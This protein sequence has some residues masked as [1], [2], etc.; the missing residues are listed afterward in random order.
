MRSRLKAALAAL[1]ISLTVGAMTAAPAA[2][3]TGGEPDGNQHPNVGLI[4]FYSPDGRFRCCA[5]LVSPTVLAH[6]GPLHRPTRSGKTAGGLPF[7]RG[8]EGTDRLPGGQARHHRLH[9][10]RDRGR[11]LPVRHRVRPPGLLRL[12][13]PGQ[14]ERRRRHRPR[15]PRDQHRAGQAR[16][17]GLPG[18]LRPAHAQQDALHLGRLWHGGAEARVRPTEADCGDLPVDPAV[19]RQPG[20]KL[21]DQVLQLNGNINDT[22][23]TGGTCFGDSGGPTFLN[24]YVVTVTSY[25]YTNNCRYLGGYQRVDIEVVQDWLATFGVF[26]TA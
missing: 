23:G 5:T 7:G 8:G 13:R 4:L 1:L 11:G 17:P 12:H 25:S 9:A 16:A 3:V 2:A 20:Q 6:G 18:R 19:R 21:T 14:L 22:R 15:P 10:G 26:P 24:G